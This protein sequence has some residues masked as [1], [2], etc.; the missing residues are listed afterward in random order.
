M[1]D[2][3][4]NKNVNKLNEYTYCNGNVILIC[5]ICYE[6]QLTSGC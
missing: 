1:C 6:Q 3:C 4:K 5:D 2:K